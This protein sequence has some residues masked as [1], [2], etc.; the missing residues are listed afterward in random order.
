MKFGSYLKP[1]GQ[2][3]LDYGQFIDQLNQQIENHKAHHELFDEVNRTRDICAIL[4]KG[5]K[6]VILRENDMSYNITCFLPN[7]VLRVLVHKGSYSYDFSLSESNLIFATEI[8]NPK[9]PRQSLETFNIGRSEM[10][11]YDTDTLIGLKDNL[12]VLQEN[13][14]SLTEAKKIIQNNDLACLTN[15]AINSS[16]YQSQN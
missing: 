8:K 12:L 14:A 1:I 10:Q 5:N 3:C 6:N 13:L 7:E 2:S 16:F 15:L 4:L 9:E 11:V